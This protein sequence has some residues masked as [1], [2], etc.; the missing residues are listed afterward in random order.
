MLCMRCTPCMLVPI[1]LLPSLYLDPKRVRDMHACY[2][3]WIFIHECPLR[4]LPLLQHIDK[5]KLLTLCSLIVLN[6][7]FWK[8]KMLSFYFDLLC[9]LW[10]EDLIGTFNMAVNTRSKRIVDVTLANCLIYGCLDCDVHRRGVTGWTL[11]RENEDRAHCTVHVYL[12]DMPVIL[13]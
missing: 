6:I 5:S 11:R 7:C 8:K 10:A 4:V 12:M 3:N 9:I 13:R 1:G 2:L